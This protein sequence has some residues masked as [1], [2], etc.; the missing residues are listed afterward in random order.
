MLCVAVALRFYPSTRVSP[1]VIS[2]PINFALYSE[3]SDS[4]LVARKKSRTDRPGE[5]INDNSTFQNSIPS[6]KSRR[7][8][9][10]LQD[11]IPDE[12]FWR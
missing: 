7:G 12:K 10:A 1:R 3:V 4:D 5:N 11:S 9:F 6:E 8:L 2:G